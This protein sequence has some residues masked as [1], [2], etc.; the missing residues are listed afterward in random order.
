M[1]SHLWA[2]SHFHLAPRKFF[3]KNQ[4]LGPCWG[5]DFTPRGSPHLLTMMSAPQAAVT[6]RQRRASAATQKPSQNQHREVLLPKRGGGGIISLRDW[7]HHQGG[8]LPGPCRA[9]QQDSSAHL[10][11]EEPTCLSEARLPASSLRSPELTRTPQQGHPT[12]CQPHRRSSTWSPPQRARGI[13]E[14]LMAAWHVSRSTPDFEEDKIP[15]SADVGLAGR[16]HGRCQA[17][18]GC[19]PATPS[20][21]SLAALLKR[22]KKKR[23]P[24]HLIKKVNTRAV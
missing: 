18:A 6:A 13:P 7:E 19:H 1:G 5:A 21:S 10:R 2:L 12:C 24:L 15:P 9:G 17:R 3:G 4:P 23:A 11:A 14:T 8:K 22:L 16:G 20:C